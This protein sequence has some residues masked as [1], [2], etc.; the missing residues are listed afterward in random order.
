VSHRYDAEIKEFD[1]TAEND[2]H[3]TMVRL[4]GEGKRVLDVGC[5]TGRMARALTA[6][7]CV[8]SGV[9]FDAAAAEESRDTLKTLVIGDLNSLDLLK[10]FGTERFDVLIFGDVLE[11][12]IDPKAVL[13]GALRLLAP[14]G[15]IVLSIPNVAHSSVRLGLLQGR[16]TYTETGLLDETHLRF[17]TPGTVLDLMSDAGLA[18]LDYQP[19]RLGPFDGSVHVDAAALPRGVVNWV[20]VQPG[21]DIYQVVLKAIRADDERVGPGL[22]AANLQL[23]SNPSVFHPPAADGS[24]ASAPR[25]RGARAIIAVPRRILGRIRRRI[26]GW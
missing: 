15:S 4:V 25:L 6:V 7:G 18:V 26:R 13:V 3:A 23:R 20:K 17:F 24:V 14:G 9:D 11:H 2:S 19:T 22:L 8:V 16:W 5:A 10:A 21:A 1:P 12:V